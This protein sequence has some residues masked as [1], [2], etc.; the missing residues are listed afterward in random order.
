[1]EARVFELGV[2]VIVLPRNESWTVNIVVV[3]RSGVRQIYVTHLGLIG[4]GQK[5]SKPGKLGG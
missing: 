3:V 1:V 4:I 2:E 5:V